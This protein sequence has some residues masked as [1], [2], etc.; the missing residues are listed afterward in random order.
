MSSVKGDE[1]TEQEEIDYH[2][3]ALPGEPTFTL[4]AN[5]ILAPEQVLN[6][7]FACERAILAGRVPETKRWKVDSA[8]R[9]AQAMKR[10]REEHVDQKDA[11]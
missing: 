6:W 10:W 3:K 11:L 9:V 4:R 7:A 8:R 1:M 5:D 2:D